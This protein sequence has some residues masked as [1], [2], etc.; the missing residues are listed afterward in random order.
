MASETEI[1]NLGLGK[2]GGAGDALNG[3]AFIS[4]I[5]GDDK[6][7]SW[8]KLAFPRVRRKVISDLA[9]SDAPFRSTARFLD[10]GVAVAAANLPEIA[11]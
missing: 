11:S 7:S 8:G 9:A 4:S 6:V 10:M 2:L 3:N 5:D 1:Y